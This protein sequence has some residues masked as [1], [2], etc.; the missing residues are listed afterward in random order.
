MDVIHKTSLTPPLPSLQPCCS[1]Q[2]VFP[3]LVL[4]QQVDENPLRPGIEEHLAETSPTST[5][6]Q[7]C[8]D[9]DGANWA[10]VQV[11]TARCPGRGRM[12]G[13]HEDAP[14]L[15]W[16]RAVCTVVVSTSQH[17][18][19]NPGH[20]Q[21]ATESGLGANGQTSFLLFTVR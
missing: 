17:H 21:G 13:M 20:Q 12:Q 4:Q 5:D 7:Q 19:V 10:R 14:S 8:L 18:W 16:K 11:S 1:S 9:V 2:E 15:E 3:T 6:L